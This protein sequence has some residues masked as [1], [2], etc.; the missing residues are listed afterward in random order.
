MQPFSVSNQACGVNTNQ[1]RLNCCLGCQLI[2]RC[3]AQEVEDRP[4]KI[5]AIGTVALPLAP[6]A[7]HADAA[8]DPA[9]AGVVE[10]AGY[11]L[12]DRKKL[13]ASTRQGGYSVWQMLA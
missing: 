7:Q 2:S 9:V 10:T 11:Y 12:R 5:R 3:Y 4:H 6:P 1:D 13:T 8:T